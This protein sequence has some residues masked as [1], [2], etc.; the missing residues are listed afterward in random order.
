MKK[1]NKHYDILLL[2]NYDYHK[3][4]SQIKGKTCKYSVFYA[5]YFILMNIIFNTYIINLQKKIKI[6]NTNTNTFYK[7]MFCLFNFQ[8]NNGTE[9]NMN[10]Y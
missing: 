1:K 9:K 3:W 7:C 10:K 8:Q 6:N 5:Q 4:F 2:I